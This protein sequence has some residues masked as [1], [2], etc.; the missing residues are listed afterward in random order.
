MIVGA[1]AVEVGTANFADPRA[2]R[3]IANQLGKALRKL[4]V[5]KA[6]DLVGTVKMSG[7]AK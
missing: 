3:R 1:S 7:S 4:N 6:A 5:T 2:P